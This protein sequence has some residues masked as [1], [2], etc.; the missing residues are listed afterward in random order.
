MKFKFDLKSD[1][2]KMEKHS[3]LLQDKFLKREISKSITGGVSGNAGESLL[4]EWSNNWSNLGWSN[5]WRNGI[6]W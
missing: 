6:N 5:A 2:K 3:G 1:A 4:P